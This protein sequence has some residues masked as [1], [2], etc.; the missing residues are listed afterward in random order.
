[1]LATEYLYANSDVVDKLLA[2]VYA[3]L[4]LSNP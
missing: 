1:M 3:C 2:F 4:Q